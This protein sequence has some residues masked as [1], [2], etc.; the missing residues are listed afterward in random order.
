[1]KPVETIAAFDQFLEARGATFSAVAIGG[2]ALALLGVIS[3]ETRDC[4]V[5]DPE[6]PNEIQRHA[7]EFAKEQTRKGNTLRADWL[8]SAIAARINRIVLR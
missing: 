1:M 4:D 3:R 6:I 7:E 5:L 8:P 2:A